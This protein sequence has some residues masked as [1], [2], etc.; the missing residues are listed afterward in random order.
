MNLLRTL[1]FLFILLCF[2]TVACAQEKYPATLLWKISGKD[3]TE[4]S[5]L[6]GTMHLQDRRL[7]Y[8]GDS[9]YTAIEKARGF[10]IEIN[11]DEMMDSLYKTMGK[12]DTSTL[13]KKIMSDAEFKKIEKKLEKKFKISADKIT[14]KKLAQ[15]KSKRRE[16]FQKKDDMPAIMDLYLFS[17]AKKQGKYT[18]G[19]EDLADQFGISD[20]IGKFDVNEFIKDDT[21]QY[22][23][24]MESMLQV[25]IN[26]DLTALNNMVNNSNAGFRD[27]LLIKRNRK[28]SVRMDSLA[29]VRTTFFAVGAAHLPGD[30]GIIS[31]LRQSG[32]TVEPV[33]ASKNINPDNYKYT[34]KETTWLT[35][36]DENK[37]CT[38]E[39]PGMPGNVQVKQILPMKMY[40]DL[41]DMSVYGI[42]VTALSEEE[43][44][45]DS[46]FD[47]LVA[48]YKEGE[49]NIKSV[50]SVLYKNCK[51][52][53][54]YAI[55]EGTAEYRYRLLIKGN[56]LFLVIF[57]AKSKQELYGSNAEKFMNSLTFNEAGIAGN[58]NWQLFTNAK[59]AFSMMAPGKTIESQQ[60]NE[61]GEIYDQYTAM[62]YNDGCY[63]MVVIR[64]TKPGYFI[65]NDSIYFE[66]YK[67]NMKTFGGYDIKEFS[68]VKFK[69]YN[70]SH[71]SAIQTISNSEILIE[72]YLIRRG[73]RTY[74]P[75]VVMPKEKA[76]F[77]QVTN[78]FRSF[79]TLPFSATEWKKQ[80]LEN[81][82]IIITA[83]GVFVKEEADTTAYNYSPD[84]VTYRAQDINS[85]ESYSFEVEKLSPL[86][87]SSSDSLFFRN[88]ANSFKGYADSMLIWKYQN[89]GIKNA[90]VLIQKPGAGIFKRF[91]FYLNGDTMYTLINYQNERDDSLTGKFFSGITFPQ[92]HPTTIFTNKATALFLALQS[93]DSSTAASARSVFNV[94][95]FTNNDLPLLYNALLQKYNKYDNNYQTVNDL[96]V[97][98][99]K[100]LSDSTVID[101]VEK[102]YLA[103]DNYAEE[104]QV[105]MLELLAEYKTA[106]SY[107]LLKRL[108]L[109][110]APN[111]GS[112]YSVI[113]AAAD[114]L[115]LIKDIFP[116]AT[117]L[118]S[119][120][121]TG[122]GIAKLA[123]NLSDS[124]MVAAA[125]I[126]QNETG[127]I[128]LADKQY[129]ELSRDKDA[130]PAYNSEV[131]VLLGRFNTDK[132]NALLNKFLLL[133]VMWV[134]NNAMLALLK[135][136]KPVAA[137]EIKK[138]AADKEWRTAFYESLREIK[139]T[140][141][142]PKEDY[143][144]LKFAESYLYSRLVEDYEVDVKATRFI[145]EKTAEIN[146]K[147]QRFLIYKVVLND[148]ESKQGY[149]AV[150]G[151][152][153]M[154]KTIAEIK[155]EDQDVYFNYDD[156]FS[157]SAVDALFK[158]Y[159]DQ[160]K[161]SLKPH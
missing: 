108:L 38:V 126:L 30:S 23:S 161:S 44:K 131:I 111:K 127:L 72:G 107:K 35:V 93:K 50:K 59:N 56:K 47:K 26:K 84:V 4:P 132:T 88:R 70:A 8:F 27:M 116:T 65:E 74:I 86:Y 61:A 115:E 153:D 121:I 76:D 68:A 140:A 40:M 92:L 37:M 146:G 159:I 96:I 28:M 7:F 34:A 104:A 154:D 95:D 101:F 49:L 9:L 58:N 112:M 103:K 147:P 19:I 114:T 129:A 142:F 139:K 67:K 75:M 5:Y 98:E 141:V 2:N 41:S 133:P 100:K 54:M 20:E 138:F 144:Q 1:L 85:A 156:A 148:D 94:I 137:T 81:N 45:S 118:Y 62:D 113:S 89:N 15:E 109:N 130:Y 134:K 87:W 152:F 53:E 106:A 78:F 55:L 42:A 151:A 157:L 150:C 90:E 11:P 13:L 125:D 22:K 46:V 25:Y 63:Y 39:M 80:Q 120:S 97:G 43:A 135:N 51:G 60:R 119:D 136:N 57:G 143:S 17:I 124:N 158:K 83:P 110:N 99:I 16:I 155:T 79:N 123:N 24:Y 32:Y 48:R 91:N 21:V 149:F 105:L 33:F 128:Q 18:G 102:H 145:K 3:L 29:H 122:P 71:F 6:Y 14:T 77:P 12:D 31:F 10:A 52:I 64:D 82:G 117:T 66:E 36:E 69:D 160:K 73:N